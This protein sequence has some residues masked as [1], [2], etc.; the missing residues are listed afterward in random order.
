MNAPNRVP[1]LIA[2]CCALVASLVVDWVNTQQ[3]GSIDLRNRVTGWRL[4][5][6][7]ID[8][9]HH[10]WSP[11]QPDTYLDLYNNPAVTVS[12]TT[13]TPAFLL[14][15]APVA[16][17]NYRHG[18]FAWLL[19]QWTCLIG[20]LLLWWRCLDTDH[21]GR[22]WLLLL[23]AAFTFTAGWRLHAERGQSYVVMLAVMAVWIT[24]SLRPAR[25]NWS[26]WLAGAA[27]GLLVALRPPLLAVVAPVLV[28]RL[29]AQW[30]GFLIAL[31]VCAG[32]PLLWDASCWAD[33]ARGMAEWSRLYRENINPR[34]GPQSFPEFIE[35]IPVDAMGRFV[36]I[37]FAD[38]SVFY[39]LRKAGVTGVLSALPVLAGFLALAGAWFW[40]ARGAALPVL[41]AGGAALAFAID[42]F[43]PAL[44]N[45]YNDILA[46]NAVAMGLV[47]L[48]PSIRR[49]PPALALAGA[50]AGIAA[51][52]FTWRGPAAINLSTLL[53]AA[54]AL[55]VLLAAPVRDTAP[56]AAADNAA[57]TRARRKPRRK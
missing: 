3:S 46:L 43:L 20:T 38:S 57:A 56:S 53:F 22:I 30:A 40:R 23:T 10:K 34:P 29:R 47:V 11:D 4:L 54:A 8:P 45:N 15:H 35:G 31:L 26:P 37:P 18:Q 6:D 55:I 42:F 17:M 49:W 12:K 50:A 51:L 14:L 36:T 24:L 21:R 25:G 13:V 16:T 9:F 33:Y 7:G 39:L 32:L 1:I 19:V 2:L 41:L 5:R 28:W 27:A 48:G 44:R 52:A